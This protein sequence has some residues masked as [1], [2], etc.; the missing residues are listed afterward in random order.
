[1]Y[2]YCSIVKKN[3][4]Y[5][6]GPVSFNSF[7]K[8]VARDGQTGSRYNVYRAITSSSTDKNW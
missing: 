1:M 5:Q 4:V 7:D 3:L 6:L 2:D 8:T